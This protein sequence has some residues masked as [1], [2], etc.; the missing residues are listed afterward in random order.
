MATLP[1]PAII[2][3]SVSFGI[4]YNTQVNVSSLSG[5][6]QT[7]EIPG[8]RWVATLSFDDLEAYEGR[9]MAAFLAELRGAGGRFYLYDHTHTSPRGAASGAE[10]VTVNGAS[11]TGNSIITTWSASGTDMLLPGDYI[12]LENK[13]LKVV[14][15]AVTVTA[16]AATI[17]FEPPIRTSP[18]D[19]SSISLVD[20]EAVMLLSEDENRWTTNNPG[21]LTDFNIDCTEG[22]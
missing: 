22:F 8:A 10:T 12:E 6:T 7:I 9:V 2:P 19:T 4:K 13:E 16:G 21:L 11:Q 18:S 20:C 1:F 15:S 3:S 17:T 5:A 14:I